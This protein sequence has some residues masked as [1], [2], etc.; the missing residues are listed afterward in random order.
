MLK[1]ILL[2]CAILVVV[3]STLDDQDFLD[4]FKIKILNRG[5]FKEYPKKG[6]S[7]NVHYTVLFLNIIYRDDF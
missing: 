4:S 7:V 1:Q 3:Q 5:T 6:D 2:V